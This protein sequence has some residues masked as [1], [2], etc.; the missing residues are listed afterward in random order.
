MT[1]VKT[2]EI[3]EVETEVL[4]D[5]EM[6]FGDIEFNKFTDL[7]TGNAIEV[8]IDN[9]LYNDLLEMA[10]DYKAEKGLSKYKVNY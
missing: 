6:Y 8:E 10:A 3:D 1:T 9:N 4:I 2:I 5:F 7:E